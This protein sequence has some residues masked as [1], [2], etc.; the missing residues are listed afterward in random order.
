M[1]ADSR[2]LFTDL[3]QWTMAQAYFES[4][5]AFQP[6]VFEL[7]FR[8]CPFGGEYAIMAGHERIKEILENFKL[9]DSEWEYL[10]KLPHFRSVNWSE[11]KKHF[12]LK[13]VELRAV[14]EGEPVFPRTPIVQVEGPLFKIQLLES[15]LL[16]AVNCSVLCSTYARRIRQIAGKR[17]LIEFGLRRAQGPDGAM[18][19]TRAAYIGG[20]DGSSNVLAGMRWKIPVYGTMAHSFVQSFEQ[21]NDELLNWNGKSIHEIFKRHRIHPQI[22]AGELASFLAYARSYPDSC[23]LLVDTYDSLASGLPNAIHVFKILRELGHEPLGIRLDSGDLVYQSKEARRMLNE[24]GFEKASIF[25]SNDLSEGIIASLQNQGA[26]IDAYG[27]G[28]HLVTCKDQPALGAVYKLVEINSHPRLKV[29]EQTSKITIPGAKNLY[30]LF[31]KD[32]K[33]LLDL[34]QTRNEPSPQAGESLWALHP[35]DAFK[36]AQVTPSEVRPLL[37]TIFKNEE[38]T[39]ELD[40]NSARERSILSIQEF[41]EDILRREYPTPYKVSVSSNLRTQ[42]ENCLKEANPTR[43]LA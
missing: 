36:K 28:T 26:Q 17:R 15:A 11:L 3:Y 39:G 23:L 5:K 20:F 37:K 19:A 21:M 4:G 8:E 35:F 25:A 14:S 38:F 41:R 16:N 40:L 22:N 31:G 1:S 33:A 18:S 24:A 13:D 30:R 34:M 12:H 27:I 32:K 29:S 7:F 6:A 43:H 2:P 42:L 9:E 10:S